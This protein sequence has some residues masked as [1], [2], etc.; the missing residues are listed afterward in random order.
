MPASEGKHARSRNHRKIL[1]DDSN[2]DD[3]DPADI[4]AAGTSDPTAAHNDQLAMQSALPDILLGTDKRPK[5]MYKEVPVKKA[6]LRKK[7]ANLWNS[8]VFHLFQYAGIN[9]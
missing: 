7:N 9:Q 2:R 4:A 6:R 3:S 8:S 5:P 1:P